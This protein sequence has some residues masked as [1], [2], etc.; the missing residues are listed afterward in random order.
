MTTA[1]TSRL[2]PREA[3][4][5]LGYTLTEQPREERRDAFGRPVVTPS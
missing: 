2:T 1:T 4:A 3:F 5:A